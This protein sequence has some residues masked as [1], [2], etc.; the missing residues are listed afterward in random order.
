MSMNLLKRF[1]VWYYIG[2]RNANTQTY[3]TYI[4]S[5][6]FD[7]TFLR[8]RTLP[9]SIFTKIYGKFE[10]KRNEMIIYLHKR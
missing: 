10:Y 3:N 9:A 2:V 6:R 7:L 4:F 5:M 1:I 8:V